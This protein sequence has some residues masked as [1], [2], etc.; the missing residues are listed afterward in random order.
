MEVDGFI[1]GP[2]G[3]FREAIHLLYAGE[4]VKP[5]Y[6]APS[7]DVT[8]SVPASDYTIVDLLPLVRMELNSFR[9]KHRTHLRDLVELGIIGPDWLPKLHPQHASRLQ[10]LLDDPHG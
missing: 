7:A 2:D 8:E 3:S 1:D 6:I 9:D 10:E 5:D 4:K